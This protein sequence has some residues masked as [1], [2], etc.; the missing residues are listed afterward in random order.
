VTI[1]HTPEEREEI[2]AAQETHVR[3][4]VRCEVC[5]ERRLCSFAPR[6]DFER[7]RWCCD[8]CLVPANAAGLT[9]GRVIRGTRSLA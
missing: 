6:R 9:D 4:L 7:K 2:A 1:E 5:G 3:P 8:A